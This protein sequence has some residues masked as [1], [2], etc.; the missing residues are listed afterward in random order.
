LA[1]DKDLT[2]TDYVQREHYLPP[3]NPKAISKKDVTVV[4][5]VLNE[6]AALGKLLTELKAEGFDRILVVDGYSND[7]T[8]QI[9]HE[10]GVMWIQQHGVGKTGAIKT[11]IE[12]VNTPYLLLMDGDYT[13]DPKDISKFLAHAENYDLIIGARTR[14]NGTIA[15]SHRFGNRFITGVFNFLFG[16][17]LS[18]V[19]SGMYLLRTETAKSLD[20]Y[21]TGF[22]VEVEIAAQVVN[23]GNI[24]EVPINYRARI[25]KQ[26]LSTWRDG[27]S[28]L[29]ATFNLARFHNPAFILSFI[30]GLI[31]LPGIG[32]LLYTLFEYFTNQPLNGGLAMAGAFLVLFGSQALAAGTISLLIKRIEGRIMRQ[33]KSIQKAQTRDLASEIKE[34]AILERKGLK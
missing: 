30:A 22:N 28:I 16:T 25:G 12:R 19:L 15:P 7:L 31:A 10:F 5:P 32:L 33:M 34:S 14:D 24:T 11:A 9:A 29:S 2:I 4:L 13:Y 1:G 21:T 26:K 27:L 20:L 18:D 3:T 17:K 23:T 8:L 6:Q